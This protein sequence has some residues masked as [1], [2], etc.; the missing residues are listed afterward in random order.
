HHFL[1]GS[2]FIFIQMELCSSSLEQWLSSNVQFRSM[3]KMKKWFKQIVEAVAYMHQMEVIHRDLK[4]S[5]ILFAGQDHLKICDLG[6]STD[7]V[8]L[9]G[10]EVTASR[11]D[12]ATPLYAAPEQTTWNYTSKVDVFSLGLIFAEMCHIM[13]V[14]ERK[15]IFDNY[16]A[17]KPND[18]LSDH[19]K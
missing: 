19:P 8:T 2:I 11:T 18:I 7:I 4:P 17:G 10:M 15:K 13:N 1:E 12:I 9:D 5:N 14:F 3:N 16:R 6:I